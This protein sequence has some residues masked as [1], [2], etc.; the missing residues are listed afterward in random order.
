MESGRAMSQ[1]HLE[2]MNELLNTRGY[3]V[4]ATGNGALKS[5]DRVPDLVIHGSSVNHPFYVIA[6]TDAEDFRQQV[7]IMWPDDNDRLQLTDSYAS[8]YHFYRCSSD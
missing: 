8:V 1:S 2:A 5:G 7:K 3:V 4:L 6:S